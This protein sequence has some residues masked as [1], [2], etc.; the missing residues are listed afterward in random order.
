MK[1]SVTGKQI[2]VGDALRSHVE[3]ELDAAV[4]KYFSGAIDA[5][6]VFSRQGS[7]FRSDCDVHVGHGIKVQGRAE[8]ADIYAAFDNTAQRVAKQLRRFKRRLRDHHANQGEADTL[9]AQS[10]VLAPEP[11]EQE[12]PGEFQPVIVAETETRITEM[13]LGD[14]VM[15]L[16]LE[17][18]PAFMFRNAA[19]ARLNVVY[20]RQDGHIGWIDPAHEVE[21]SD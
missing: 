2:D 12:A 10:Y 7:S 20:R 3:H 6:V 16:E 13:S 11:E 14:A 19:N 21:G 5:H 15:R 8:A 18:S 9:T 17:D 1:V 4:T